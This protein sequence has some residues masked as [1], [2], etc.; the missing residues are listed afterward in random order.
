M[1][2]LQSVVAQTETA[3]ADISAVLTVGSVRAGELRQHHP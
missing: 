3:P 1:L 2:G